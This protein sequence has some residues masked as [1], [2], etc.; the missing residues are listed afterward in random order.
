MKQNSCGNSRTQADRLPRRLAVTM[1]LASLVPCASFAQGYPSKPVRYIV[2]APPGG[3]DDLI[4]R[5]MQPALSKVLGQSVVVDYRPRPC[6][7]ANG[8]SERQRIAGRQAPMS[9][10]ENC[11]GQIECAPPSCLGPHGFHQTPGS[12]NL[13][14]PFEVIGQ[15]VQTHFRADLFQGRGKEMRTAR[16]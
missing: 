7:N 14:H 13:D 5:L 1:L 15:H 9:M 10:L 12:E 11:C 6:E 3:T 8:M 4:A 16:P 2:R